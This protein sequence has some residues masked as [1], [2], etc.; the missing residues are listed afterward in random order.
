MSVVIRNYFLLTK[1]IIVLLLLA[2]TITTMLFAAGGP[3]PLT[4][5]LATIVGGAL[6]AGGANAINCSFDHDIDP[7]M[8]RT[9][10]RPTVS[11]AVQP[12]RAAIFGIALGVISFVL[13]AVFVNLLSAILAVAGLLFYVLFYTMYLKRATIHNIVIGGA[14][15][16]IP[17]LV[18][19]A[20]AT[21]RLDLTAWYLFAIVFFW[22]PPHFWALALLTKKEYAAA[23]VPMLPVIRGDNETRRQILLYSVLMLPVTMLLYGGQS[24]GLV[25]L[26]CAVVLGLLFVW[27][28]YR[29]Y[30]EH[31]ARRA[32]ALF[33]FSNNYLALLF[34][35]M[36][37]DRLFFA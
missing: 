22:T 5:V 4:I 34:V 9:R 2:T 23:G 3:P 6:A 35:A 12:S 16:S 11:G 33:V 21:G 25:Y 32:R 27:Y 1:P 19:W 14:A 30:V 7:L 37:V 31:T 28:A 36:V 20:A 13:L 15:G 18:G 26:A 10:R 17:P 24:M 8:A 29:L